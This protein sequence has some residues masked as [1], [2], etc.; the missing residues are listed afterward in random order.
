[1][2]LL[3][4]YHCERHLDLSR[5]VPPIKS[6]PFFVVPAFLTGAVDDVVAV[7]M[8]LVAADGTGTASLAVADGVGAVD[9]ADSTGVGGGVALT[10]AG[11]V[12][13]DA[14]GAIAL[15]ARV[16]ARANHTAMSNPPIA[17]ATPSTTII[18][19]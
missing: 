7:G 4:A 14:R 12:L 1:M 10:V 6:P 5:N 19:N 9:T 3:T 17:I 2:S 8:A 15:S 16:G 18:M 11:V 13:V